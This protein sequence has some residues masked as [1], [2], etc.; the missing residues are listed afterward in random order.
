M[1]EVSAVAGQ[2]ATLHGAG[3]AQDD[4]RVISVTHFDRDGQ[5]AK[6]LPE[7]EMLDLECAWIYLRHDAQRM[8]SCM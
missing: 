5:L 6:N 7:V 4:R 3:H 2:N 1:Q 8:K